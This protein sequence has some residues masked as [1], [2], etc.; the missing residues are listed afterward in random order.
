MET[1][2]DPTNFPYIMTYVF[3]EP[4]RRLFG[5]TIFL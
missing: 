1:H 3:Y 2:I 5:M 4:R